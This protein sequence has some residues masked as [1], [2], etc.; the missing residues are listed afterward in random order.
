MKLLSAIHRLGS[1]TRSRLAAEY[2]LYYQDEKTLA[3]GEGLFL[4]R[5][6]V[7]YACAAGWNPSH[8]LIGV[9][10]RWRA[11]CFGWPHS[12]NMFKGALWLVRIVTSVEFEEWFSPKWAHNPHCPE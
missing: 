9:T 2:R 6:R 5:V 11:A 8:P 12:S 4:F 7:G 1:K 3:G 10:F